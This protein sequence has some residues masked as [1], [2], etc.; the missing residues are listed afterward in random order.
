[1]TDRKEIPEVPTPRTVEIG[2]VFALMTSVLFFV[3]GSA[4]A[5]VGATTEQESAQPALEHATTTPHP[6]SIEIQQL[7]EEEDAGRDTPPI[8]SAMEPEVP[9][10]DEPEIVPP[11]DWNDRVSH[12]A[13]QI[14][15][16]EAEPKMADALYKELENTLWAY[17]EEVYDALRSRSPNALEYRTVLTSMYVARVRLLEWVTP[18]LRAKLLGTGATAMRE[19]RR[20]YANAKLEFFFQALAI[21]RGL[22]QLVDGAREYPLDDVW[23]FF[24]LFFC[25]FVFRTWRGW[26]KAGL[27]DVRKRILNIRPQN[28]MHIQVAQLLWYLDRFRSPL[29]WLLL[30]SFVSAIFE[31]GDLEEVSTLVSVILLWTLLTRFGLLL[32]DALAARNV[33]HPEDRIPG[34]RLRSLRLV[35]AWILLTGLGLDLT[36]RYVGEAAIYT[37]VTRVSILLLFPVL[38]LLLHWWRKSIIQ[39]LKNDSSFS[40]IAARMGKRENGLRSY[41]NAAIGSFY[42][43]GATLLQLLIRAASHFESGRKF[44]ATLLRREVERDAQEERNAEKPISPTL[45]LKLLEPDGALIDGP[46][47]E[48][49]DHIKGLVKSGRGATVAVLAERGGGLSTFLHLAKQTVGDTMR[50]V[51]CPPSGPGRFAEALTQELG[52]SEDVDL[53]VDLQPRLEAEEIRVIAVDNYHRLARP[54]MD[55]L[56][57]MEQAAAIASAA[58]D[59]VIWI[60]TLSRASWPYISRMLGDRAILQEILELPAWSESQLG[61]LLDNRCRGAGIDPDY[62]QLDFPRQFDDG[63]RESLD[64]RNRFGFRRVLWEMSDGNPEVAMRLFAHS[65][66]ELPSGK[67]IV[68]LPRP[69]SSDRVSAVN[70]STLLALKVLVETEMA[71]IDDLQQAIQAPRETVINA[72]HHCIQEQWVEEIYDHYQITWASYRT[73]KRVLIRR[74]LIAR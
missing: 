45:F 41:V 22:Q 18:G 23:R 71:T 10:P 9:I 33:F 6:H 35:A 30:I 63:E 61:E 46:F 21:P 68:R 55:G 60:V 3:A 70:R 53:E 26:A 17:Q 44:V 69:A 1:L 74:G 27:P 34:L 73:V 13:E 57:G 64:D 37:A 40:S 7:V 39:R 52:L 19:L 59:D 28:D 43:L 48:G 24:Q 38:F 67:I 2:L 32:V 20:E 49:L 54:Q 66:R 47:Q 11:T 25:I 72:I 56:E 15:M 14:E 5:D 4:W 8:D 29:E 50:I 42:I 58:G 65:L 31:P 51:D 16:G 12:L 36:S 62:G